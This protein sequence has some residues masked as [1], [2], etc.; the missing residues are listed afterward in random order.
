MESNRNID[1]LTERYVVTLEDRDADY[2]TP[3]ETAARLSA[4][5]DH[6]SQHRRSGEW[7][8]FWSRRYIISTG[9]TLPNT[10]DVEP[11]HYW[12]RNIVKRG[13]CCDN[14]YSGGASAA[15]EPGHFDVRTSS[16][17][18]TRMHYF[19]QKKLTTFFQSSPS[20]HKC[21]QR[22][23]DCF[24]VEIKQIKRSAVGYGKI[25][26]LCSHYYGSKERKKAGRSQGGG[27]S[28]QVIWL[29]AP[30]CSAATECLS[31]CLTVC[32]F[33][34]PSVCLSYSRVMPERFK[35]SKYSLLHG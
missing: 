27:L 11:S 21:R 19:P 28:S 7:R 4:R 5:R 25:F 33:V 34:C 29:G 23:W 9:V 13:I 24:T 15:K 20:K 16:S 3:H 30:W 35:I 2:W 26:I 1:G 18:V 10:S 32:P 22:C 6:D 8:L 31:V 14:V 12:L 17:Q